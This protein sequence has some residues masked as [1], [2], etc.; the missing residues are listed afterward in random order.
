[1]SNNAA[2]DKK[3]A[4]AV[5]GTC[6]LNSKPHCFD[7][8]ELVCKNFQPVAA[9]EEEPR[10]THGLIVKWHDDDQL[11]V[12]R[13]LEADWC[14]GHGITREAAIKMCEDNF[15]ELAAPPEASE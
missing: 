15:Q 4:S 5:L 10:D 8:C 11:F 6:D 1:M 3:A 9:P 2:S 13:I 14:T 12:A 7:S